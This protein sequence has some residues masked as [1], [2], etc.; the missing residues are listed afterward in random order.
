MSSIHLPRWW[1]SGLD[2]CFLKEE[3]KL[4]IFSPSWNELFQVSKPCHP[5][6]KWNEVMPGASL[7]WRCCADAETEAR[8]LAE[9]LE[10]PF[11]LEEDVPKLC[12]S[13]WDW[14]GPNKE[15]FIPLMLEA[16]RAIKAVSSKS[17]GSHF[18]S[19]WESLNSCLYSGKRF[20]VCCTA[21]L[22][23]VLS[24][25]APWELNSVLCKK[26]EIAAPYWHY[27]LPYIWD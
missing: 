19:I 4:A 22:D 13:G 24:P 26:Y 7:R 14:E 27:L 12:P 16:Y 2:L 5:P 17:R 3:S 25:C 1:Q 20:V 18:S 9:Q 6:F 15:N 8:Q 23:L 10:D 11:L 21:C